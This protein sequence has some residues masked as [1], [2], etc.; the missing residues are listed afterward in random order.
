LFDLARET[1][2]SLRAHPLRFGLTSL[3]IVWGSF[4]LTYLSATM[5]GVDAHFDREMSE[6]GPR[7]VLV[8]PGSIFKN[9]V[10]ERGARPVELEPKD[11]RRVARLHSVE[12]A[13]PNL[14]LWSLVVRAGRRTKLFNVIG[15]GLTSR[16]IRNLEVAEGRYFSSLDL[17]RAARVAVLGPIARERLFGRAPALGRSFQI[18]SLSF[19]VIGVLAAK[20]DQLVSVNGRDDWAVFVPYTT[21]QRW[22][23]Q[24]DAVE[25]FALSPVTREGSW[26]SI[27]HTRQVLGLHHHFAPELD[28]ALYVFNVQD[29]LRIVNT[30]LTGLR[31]FQISAG[32]I[33]LLVG[34]VGVMN[35]MLVVVSE[36]RSEIGLRK[37]V[38]AP[39]R[40]IFAQFLAEA[41]ALCTLSGLLGSALGSAFTQIVAGLL[42]ADTPVSSPPVLNLALVV[43]L[44][45]SLVLVGVVA[46]VV[47]ALRAARVEPSEAL[48]A[49]Y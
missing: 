28:T 5:E 39:G 9:R 40:A 46:G 19:R 21:A 29:L 23:V 33:T 11:V 15:I 25:Q 10:G 16:G 3:G 17:S 36:R 7:L 12:A 32:L 43:L 47:P 30:V 1:L 4:L 2:R 6:A 37:A 14:T 13:E 31:V 49:I 38:G 45:G 18:E 42:P 27:R 48:R 20:G 41:A 35:I 8:T 24:S 26:D 22:F 44:T 34:A